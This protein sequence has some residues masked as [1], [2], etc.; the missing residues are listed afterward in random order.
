LNESP[1]V[2]IAGRRRGLDV[3]LAARAQQPT[4]PVIAFLNPTS[5]DSNVDL[6][7]AFRLGL[8]ESGY[9]EGENVAIE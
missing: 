9:V 5:L 6:L 2:H 4:M 1:H 8:T 3:P 7:R